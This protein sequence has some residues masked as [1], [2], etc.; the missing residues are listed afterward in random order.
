M[1]PGED[2]ATNALRYLYLAPTSRPSILCRPRGFTIQAEATWSTKSNSW[3]AVAVHLGL[4]VVLLCAE[5]WTRAKYQIGRMETLTTSRASTRTQKPPQ[6]EHVDLTSDTHTVSS[7]MRS[8]PLHSEQLAD[9][10][11]HGEDSGIYYRF[12]VRSRWL[13]S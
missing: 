13:G 11:W 12:S 3:D 5:L 2:T 7:T 10:A 8:S 4:A 9:P 6:N 1:C